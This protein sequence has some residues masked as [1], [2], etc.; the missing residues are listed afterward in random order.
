[1]SGKPLHILLVDDQKS[2]RRSLSLMLLGA[3]FDTSE[4]ESGSQALAILSQA[5][6]DLVITD[7]RMDDMSGIDLLR[8]I[9]QVK[10]ELPVILITAYGSIES[11]VDAMRLG[12]FDY[13]TK[14]F[15]EHDILE[16]IRASQ[17]LRNCA[18]TV[19]TRPAAAWREA[20]DV[21]ADTPQMRATLI[22]AERLAATDIS[23]LITGETGTGKTRIA[24]LIHE[25]SARSEHAFVS[26]NCAS[27]PEQLLE[28]EL[29]GHVRGSFTGA[30]DSRAGLF[31]EADAGTIFLDEVDT[32]SPTM[33][34][35]LLSVL[36]ERQIRRVGS[37]K[38]RQVDIRV[39]SAT[40]QVLDSLMERGHFRSDLYFR[41]NGIRLHLPPLR[42]RGEDLMRLLARFLDTHSAK[43]RRSGLRLTPRALACVQAYPYPGNIRQLENFVEQ[44]VVFADEQGMID[45]SAL[46]EDLL[47]HLGGLP[48]A[49]APAPLPQ[50]E[51]GSLA[52]TER[53]LI[54]SAL[55][56]ARHIGEAA[57]ELGIGRT[58]LWRKMR[59]FNLQFTPGRRE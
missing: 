1:M 8:E 14:P 7:L 24:R 13:L 59:E 9:K 44:M 50:A 56:R 11:A 34:A 17:T 4:A 40:N 51:G 19:R 27:L 3:G 22:K 36:Q 48:E 26:I 38:S 23:V 47:Q 45:I 57:R 41:L 31:E 43:Y 12:A 21:V 52:K 18:A 46:P 37:N 30:T 20:E 28:S 54:E 53:M 6:Y 25:K 58:T 15:S 5:E 33:Q 16:K 32:L 10:P 35:K 39:I 55:Q 49:N 29:F 2:L 42:E